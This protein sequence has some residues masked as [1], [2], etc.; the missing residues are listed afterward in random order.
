MPRGRC[1]STQ[2]VGIV[3]IEN[4]AGQIGLLGVAT[5]NEVQLD[6]VTAATLSPI[7]LEDFPGNIAPVLAGQIPGLTVRRAFR[8]ADVKATSEI[9]VSPVEPD[10][11][12][13]SQDTLSLGEDRSLLASNATVE[14]TRAGIFRLSFALPAGM[15]VE[16]ITGQALSHWTELKTDAERII[17]MHLRGRT[18]G[19]QEFAISLIGPGVKATKAWVAPQLTFRE[20]NKQRGTFLVV[21][22]QGMRLQ[23]TTRDGVTQLDPQK[24]GIKQKG[25]LAFRI[26]QT[27]WSLA[28]DIEQVDP[29]VQ[30][31]GLQHATV[32]EALVKVTA[33]LLYQIENTG[34]K[35]FRVMLPTNAENVKFSGDQ[36]ADFLIPLKVTDEM[37][38]WD[39][40]LHRRVI[41]E[42]LLQVTYQ[43]PLPAN[44]AETTLFPVMADG[45]NLQ[46][47]F[48][49]VQSGGRLQVRVDAIPPALQTVEW[50]S[51]P[52]ALQKDLTTSSA[53]YAFRLVETNFRLPLKLERHEATKL[54][55]AHVNNI[56]F[57]SVI[58]DS[59]TMLTEVRLEI[60]PG[61][62][63]LLHLTLPKDAQF[64]FAFV[65]QNGVWP[66]REGD[67]IL[68]PLEQQSRT[69]EAIPVSLFYTSQIGDPGRTALDLE[70]LAPKFELP[71]ENVTWNVFLNQ[72][73]ELKDWT[74]SLQM[75]REQIVG[76][77]AA[78]DVQTY[79]QSEASQQR[80]K[81]KAAEKM[82]AL[83]NSALEEGNPQQARRAFESAFGLSQ[84]DN[85]FNEDARVQLHNLK[86]QQAIVGLNVR[87][88]TVTGTPDALAGKLRGGTGKAA[89]YTQQDAK[90]I[91][92]RNT[93]DENA[94]FSKLAERLIQQQDAALANP[95]TIRASVPEQGRLLT[96]S[97]SVAV[98]HWADLR[99]GLEA[100]AIQTASWWTRLLILGGTALVL[101][102]LAL[103]ARGFNRRHPAATQ[104]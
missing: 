3:A 17:T 21:P 47:G 49:T 34:L 93:A 96:F 101:G 56:T 78:V 37:T 28:V 66:W 84:G 58:S 7:N 90:Q 14:I 29:W 79:L 31:S 38:P 27:P 19:K 55:P 5:G 43:V 68:I 51:I 8:Y 16:S 61:D 104:P 97:R 81:T 2:S 33:N 85:A 102:L 59:G 103:S 11:R 44:A 98:D 23:V 13:E 63:R 86:L 71:L 24:S 89:N 91:I 72:R 54:L 52:R 80:E 95:A 76:R 25:V 4:A 46:R 50:Q 48:V 67:E 45:V 9:K 35:A 12:V 88:S 18:E 65:N 92:D 69:G 57:T 77:P 62:M 1:H 70:L 94:A 40:K 15:D 64:W 73:W 53:S 30:V 41:G 75:Q 99:I 100:K 87:N 20:A 60:L 10:V 83:G 82:L 32:G 6:T 39:V 42:Y 36:V 26:L 22:E 74:G